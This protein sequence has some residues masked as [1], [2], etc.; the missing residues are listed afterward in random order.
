MK[1]L[2]LISK[3]NFLLDSR[4]FPDQNIIIRDKKVKIGCV[5]VSGASV[6]AEILGKTYVLKQEK[7]TTEPGAFTSYSSNIDISSC[8]EDIETI[9]NEIEEKTGQRLTLK[10]TNPENYYLITKTELEKMGIGQIDEEFIVNYT[11][12]EV[13]NKTKKVTKDKQALYIYSVE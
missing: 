11:T 5:A 6:E 12:G 13:I 7:E 8:L 10:D 2:I 1:I 4:A 9:T 3:N